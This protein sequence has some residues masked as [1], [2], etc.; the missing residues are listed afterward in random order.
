MFHYYFLN[1]F[2]FFTSLYFLAYSQDTELPSKLKYDL[3]KRSPWDKLPL[4]Q[5]LLKGSLL[6]RVAV[7]P[8][9]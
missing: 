3:L 5:V 8:N 4:L 2:Y 9:R 7:P 6:Y 1:Y